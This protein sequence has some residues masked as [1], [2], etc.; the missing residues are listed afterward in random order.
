MKDVN[1][2]MLVQSRAR[3]ASPG[4]ILERVPVDVGEVDGSSGS[5][6]KSTALIFIDTFKPESFNGD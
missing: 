4:G 1:L 6:E 2:S 5:G 3:I